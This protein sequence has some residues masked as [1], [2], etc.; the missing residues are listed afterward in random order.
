MINKKRLDTMLK[1][2]QGELKWYLINKLKERGRKVLCK[3]GFIY[4]EGS[5]SVL[6]CAHMDTVYQTPPKEI[7]KIKEVYEVIWRSKDGIGGDDRCGIEIILSV[8]EEGFDVSIAF[9]EDEEI[10]GIGAEKFTRWYKEEIEAERIKKPNFIIE[11]DRQALYEAVFY[12]C[13]NKEF[14]EFC[15]KGLFN[16]KYGSFSDISVIAPQIDVAAVNVSA[17][18]YFEHSGDS[19]FIIPEDVNLNLKAVIEL[20]KSADDTEYS[21]YPDIEDDEEDD[22]FDND[23][24]WL[25]DWNDKDGNNDSDDDHEGASDRIRSWIPERKEKPKKKHK[26]DENFL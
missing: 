15:T 9:L 24:S 3:D 18:Y 13:R 8:I 5:L 7:T 16:K 11:V 25:W 23:L 19:E 26:E 20:L 12:S 10:G 22:F 1:K 6:M 4:S 2:D 14:M 21:Y 17:G